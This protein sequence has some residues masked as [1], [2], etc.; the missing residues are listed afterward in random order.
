MDMADLDPVAW[1]NE[2]ADLH[3]V[4][5]ATKD[6]LYDENGKPII[7][8]VRGMESDGARAKAKRVARAMRSGRKVDNDAEG[9]ELLASL[10]IDWKG[11]GWKGVVLDCTPTNIRMLLKERDWIGQQILAFASETENFFSAASSG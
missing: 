4:H 11:I 3:L 7:I 9:L 8:R 1:S 6:P 2:G 5:P 10:V